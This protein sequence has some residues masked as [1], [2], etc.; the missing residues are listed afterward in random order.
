MVDGAFQVFVELDGTALEGGQIYI[1][2]PYEDPEASPLTVYWDDALTIPAAQPLRTSGGVIVDNGSPRDVFAPQSTYS[3]RVRDRAGR[4]VWYKPVTGGELAASRLTF[5]IPTGPASDVPGPAD[6]TY[7]NLSTFKASDISRKTASL[8]GVPGIPDGRFNWTLG[9]YTGQA[10]DLNIIK[11][12]STALS[13]GAWVRQQA[14]GITYKDPDV[15]DAF[16]RDLQRKAGETKSLLDFIP[17]SMRAAIEDY[18][19]TEDHTPYIQAAFDS[20]YRLLA[21]AGR[22]NLDATV[23]VKMRTR[24]YLQGASYQATLF[25]L[26][27]GA[28]AG[29]LINYLGGFGF[30]RAFTLGSANPYIQGVVLRDFAVILNHPTASITTTQIQVGIDFRNITRSLIDGVYV[31]NVTPEQFVIPKTRHD[32][33]DQQGYGI[34]L[35]TLSGGL[36]YAGGEGNRLRDVLVWGAY[37]GV[38]QDDFTLSPLSSAH[39]TKIDGLDVQLCHDALSQESSYATGC[40]YRDLTLQYTIR[41]AGNANPTHALTLTGYN[42][43]AYGTYI[44]AG[45]NTDLLLNFD[46]GSKNNFVD[47]TYYDATAVSSGGFRDVGT[48]NVSERFQN[49]GVGTAVNCA[50]SPV[51]FRNNAYEEAQAKFQWNGTAIAIDSSVGISSIVRNGVGDYTINFGKNMPNTNYFPEVVLDTGPSGYAGSYTVPITSLSVGGFRFYTYQQNGGTTTQI[52]P[53]R[54]W[55]KASQQG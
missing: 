6:N 48:N 31:G 22:Y 33:Y 47:L 16:S 34:L 3:I 53:R 55:L 25:W 23:G 20:G 2:V 44:E 12:D 10:D 5:P 28:T 15:P 14:S 41:Q 42:N 35:G 1:G 30:G 17:E 32:G 24:S 21:P 36:S 8:V 40:T 11:A 13:V 27:G 7:S 18:S 37:K 43:Y 19:A 39:A 45:A 46:T 49:T 50:G 52:D 38:S 29:E 26:T 51:R 4:V 54:V 9:N